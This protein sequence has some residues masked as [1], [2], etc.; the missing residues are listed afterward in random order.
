MQADQVYRLEQG[1]FTPSPSQ[2]WLLAKA[3]ILDPEELARWAIWQLLTR[4]EQLA[5]HIGAVHFYS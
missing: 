2:A 4:P 3:L 5:E 1:S